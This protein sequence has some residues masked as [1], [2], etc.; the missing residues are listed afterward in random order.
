MNMRITNLHKIKNDHICQKVQV[1]HVECEKRISLEM[2]WHMFGVNLQIH[3]FVCGKSWRVHEDIKMGYDR[4][5][6]T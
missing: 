5:K 2:V 4:S 3:W 6:I 1:E